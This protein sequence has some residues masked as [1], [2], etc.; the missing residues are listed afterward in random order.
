MAGD[1]K[2]KDMHKMVL[3][4]P[5][6]QRSLLKL[7]KEDAYTD[8]TLKMDDGREFRCHRLVLASK[9]D[10]FHALFSGGFGES[11]QQII[12]IKN[13]KSSVME[14][15]LEYV[16][17]FKVHWGPDFSN[18]VFQAVKKVSEKMNGV[19]ALCISASLPLCIFASF[20]WV[21]ETL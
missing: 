21:R 7:M 15:V 19:F 13:M 14:I 2:E 3:E 1:K 5:G 18:S 8:V 6:F 16:Y 9:S 12:P 10:Y 20:I 4:G 11:S 17:T